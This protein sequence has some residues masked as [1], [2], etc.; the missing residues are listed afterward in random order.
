MTIS[1]CHLSTQKLTDELL[2]R[3]NTD[4]PDEAFA[5]ASRCLMEA[6]DRFTVWQRQQDRKQQGG[7][8]NYFFDDGNN[9]FDE[10]GTLS[11][12]RVLKSV[13]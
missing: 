3:Q 10:D 6:A 7:D 11:F 9:F 4:D 1:M 2:S 8:D 5:M 12:Q 13:S